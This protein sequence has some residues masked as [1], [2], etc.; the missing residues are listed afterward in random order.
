MTWASSLVC[1]LV[2]SGGLGSLDLH[3]SEMGMTRAGKAVR[4]GRSSCRSGTRDPGCSE[5][6]GVGHCP[7]LLPAP[8]WQVLQE[9]VNSDYVP[10]CSWHSCH[11]GI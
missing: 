7:I 1:H 2:S 3:M 5:L 11:I 9:L 6:G 10:G 8:L 4:G